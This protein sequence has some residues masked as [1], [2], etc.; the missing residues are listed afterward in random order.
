MI[1]G[2]TILKYFDTADRNGKPRDYG[3]IKSDLPEGPD[4][5]FHIEQVRPQDRDRVRP[6]A[7]VM[8]EL[9]AKS[10]GRT[11]ASNVIVEG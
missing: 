4:V 2:G 7:R 3:F 1:E 8:F 5:F 10:G 11:A 9:V 6:G